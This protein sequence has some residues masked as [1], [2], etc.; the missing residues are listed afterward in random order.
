MPAYF[1]LI[2]ILLSACASMIATGQVI[3]FL[4][5]KAILDHPNERSSHSLPTPRGGG[6]GI[7]FVILPCLFV[8]SSRNMPG[9]EGL[10]AISVGVLVLAG[11]SWLDD[12]KDLGAGV[13]FLTQ[14]LVVT[15]CLVLMENPEN[16]YLGGV[17]PV[18]A[19]KIIL[20]FGWL[21]FINLFNFMDGIDGIS[22]VEII[23]VAGGL[24]VIAL[25]VSFPDAYAF[26]CFIIVGAALGFLR[27][28][29]HPAKVFMGDVGSISIG[30]L[31]GW[32]LITMAGKGYLLVAILLPL[33]Y[34][35]DATI[36]LLRRLLR[37]EKIWQ[38]HRE[39]FYQ[40]AVQAGLRHDHVALIILGINT[41]LFLV[42]YL[43]V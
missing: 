10:M 21:W 37:G 33:Y 43:I 8:L 15:V 27:W 38:A 13:R 35:S 6:L 32:L 18:W 34:L 3:K 28:N 1:Y 22:A 40:K 20:G 42:A 30:F 17:L 36:T 31:L 9:L 26:L 23:S 39:H 19:E 11:L 7:L 16:G 12:L 29:W 41:V 4:Q 25:M 24:G 5:K 2:A 14:I